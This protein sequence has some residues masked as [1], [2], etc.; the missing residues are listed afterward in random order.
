MANTLTS[1]QVAAVVAGTDPPVAR[2]KPRLN[3]VHVKFT[4]AGSSISTDTVIQ[5][6]AV[7]A[8]ARIMDG[9]VW[10]TDTTLI[11][12][13]AYGVGDGSLTSRFISAASFSITTGVM[14]N[15]FSGGLGYRISLSDQ[16]SGGLLYDTIDFNVG[17]TSSCVTIDLHM[18]VWYTYEPDLQG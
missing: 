8:N 13:T 12:N 15:R 10:R 3:A 11:D 17:A 16:A 5:M 1:T 7:P 14:L 6:V 18:S 4:S 9:M 2:T